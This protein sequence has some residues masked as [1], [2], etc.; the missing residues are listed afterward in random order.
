MK[1]E[2][3][4]QEVSSGLYVGQIRHRRFTPVKH[5]FDY[6]IFMSLIDLD[7]V[8]ELVDSVRFLSKRK[9]G[10]MSFYRH[11][12]MEGAEDT[13]SAVQEKLYQLTGESISG[14]VFAL[15]HL[16]YC[17]LYF[18][19]VNFYYVF[20]DNNKWNYMLAEVSNT[21]WNE[22]H[23]YAIP[24]N[25]HW[26]HEKQFHVSPFNP[27]DQ[28]YRWTLKPIGDTAF[29]HLE[30]CQQDKIFDATLFLK[31]KPFTSKN[32]FSLLLKT[33][34]MTIKVLGLIYWQALKLWLKGA[35]FYSHPEK[36]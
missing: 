11:D 9:W 1:K 17:G 34:V 26:Q 24:A 18:S 13:K 2:K 23:Y 28:E 31:K 12:Y 19:P 3:R 25:R 16:R 15:C 5:I 30:T 21:P 20:D 29:V 27:L 7:K 32:V 22:R 35:I 6:P 8:D 33:P 36:S 14:K 4:H 10:L